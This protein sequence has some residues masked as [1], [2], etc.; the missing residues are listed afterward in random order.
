MSG[1]LLSYISIKCCLPATN[2]IICSEYQNEMGNEIF[3]CGQL[4]LP[5]NL[6]KLCLSYP[7][8]N[9]LRVINKHLRTYF[10]LVSF[11]TQNL[12]EVTKTGNFIGNFSQDN[13]YKDF[14]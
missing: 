10:K 7:E 8:P 12:I 1:L 5:H 2:C 9:I 14:L 13:S 11:R 6:G 3:L 4:D